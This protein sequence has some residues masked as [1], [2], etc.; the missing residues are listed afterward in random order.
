VQSFNGVVKPFGETRPA[1]K[2][3]RVLGSLLGLPGFDFESVD[4]VRTRLLPASA[5]IAAKLANGTRVAID[6]PAVATRG[7]ERVAEVPI[8][9]ADA[10]ARRAPSLQQAA[11]ARPPRARMN[12]LT[13]QQIGV[14][15]GAALKVRQGRGEAVLTAMIDPAVPSGVVRIAAAHPSTC[16]LEGL[17]GSITVERA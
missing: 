9:F 14:A 7:F 17:S 13:L 16:G 2:V 1:W 10:L 8:Y 5:A 6:R 11:D 4:D 3:L 15:E 12:A